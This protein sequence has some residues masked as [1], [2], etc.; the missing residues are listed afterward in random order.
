M[1]FYVVSETSFSEILKMLVTGSLEFH[2]GLLLSLH[3]VPYS[4][5]L[6]GT[7]QQT[8]INAL[9]GVQRKNS[10]IVPLQSLLKVLH[11]NGASFLLLTSFHLE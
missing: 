6:V 1:V 11:F 7:D 8:T 4:D 5:D 9:R 2:L 3:Q 10:I